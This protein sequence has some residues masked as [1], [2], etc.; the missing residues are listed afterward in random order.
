MARVNLAVLKH[1]LLKHPPMAVFLATMAVS[2]SSCFAVAVEGEKPWLV[3]SW[4]V[5]DGI[6][7]VT[8]KLRDPG[9]ARF[10]AGRAKGA[11]GSKLLKE[12]QRLR[13]EAMLAASSP[14][15]SALF[16][17]VA[18]S[19]SQRKQRKRV[20]SDEKA[21][22]IPSVAEID[23]PNIFN[24][25]GEVVAAARRLKVVGTLDLGASIKVELKEEVLQYIREAVRHYRQH[26]LPAEDEAEQKRVTWSHVH[27]CWRACRY[28]AEPAGKRRV[29]RAFRPTPGDG[30]ENSQD[31]AKRWANGEDVAESE[32]AE[33]E[34][35]P[36]ADN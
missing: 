28:D 13:A 25:Q 4:D 17:E 26:E 15:H 21:G 23:A 33:G 27:G 14:E 35:E 2:I 18:D 11:F 30:P 20:R 12:L 32:G 31:L 1:N 5:V 34:A 36:R 16:D 3:T 29:T 24:T 7:F 9:F 8:I 10:V 19:L 22:A 6:T